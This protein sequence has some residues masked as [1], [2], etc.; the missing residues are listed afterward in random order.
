VGETRFER[1]KVASNPSL[2]VA[3]S[4]VKTRY[5]EPLAIMG[6]G[7]SAP[8]KLARRPPRVSVP[9]YTCKHKTI[10]LCTPKE[11]MDLYLEA[12]NSSHL[13]KVTA[14]LKIE[15]RERYRRAERD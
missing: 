3:L 8:L 2:L 9:A 14:L 7:I 11:F 15:I 12:E 4:D 6:L 1:I 5:S 10:D 13:Q